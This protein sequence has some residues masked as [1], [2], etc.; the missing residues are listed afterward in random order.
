MQL[1]QKY[2][3]Q[4]Q[5]DVSLTKMIISDRKEHGQL[6]TFVHLVDNTR[7]LG[8]TSILKLP[9]RYFEIAVD[10]H[11]KR[12]SKILPASGIPEQDRL[13]M[14]VIAAEELIEAEFTGKLEERAAEDMLN[15]AKNLINPP[16]EQK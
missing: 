6:R 12:A 7:F 14:G 11:W 13:S 1:L 3:S 2:N 15:I 5:V 4:E 10:Y 8:F 9:S 16:D